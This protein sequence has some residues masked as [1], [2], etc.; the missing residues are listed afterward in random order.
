MPLIDSKATDRIALRGG[1]WCEIQ[2][3]MSQGDLLEIQQIMARG[4]TFATGSDEKTMTID[5]M[6]TD[7]VLA[8][9]AFAALIVNA[10][11]WSMAEEDGSPIPLTPD[12][13]RSLHPEDYDTLI[14]AINDRNQ[15][16]TEEEKNASS[17]NSWPQSKETEAGPQNSPT[18]SSLNGA[19]GGST[20]PSRRPRSSKT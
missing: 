20:T 12:T 18:S 1:D 17:L 3:N 8:A 15:R 11:A 5:G 10:K 14:I 2:R 9:S 6:N 4:V 16:R 13:L 7:D 19:G